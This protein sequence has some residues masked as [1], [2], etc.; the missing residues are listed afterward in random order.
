VGARGVCVEF[1]RRTDHALRQRRRRKAH[2]RRES[3][4]DCAERCDK[5]AADM[6]HVFSI[7]FTR[8]IPIRRAKRAT[9]P[10]VRPFAPLHEDAASVSTLLHIYEVARMSRINPW[11]ETADLLVGCVEP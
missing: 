1:L 4:G 2:A 3:D 8:I 9:G 6:R 11:V 10:H 5:D 7:C